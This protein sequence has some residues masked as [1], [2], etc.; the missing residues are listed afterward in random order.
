[1]RAGT[2]TL[3]SGF[4]PRW[5]SQHR[6]LDFAAK[7]GTPIYAAQGGTV[8]YI[9]RADGFGQWIVIDHPRRRRWRHDRLRTHVG[10]VRHRT[11]SRAARRGR[12]AHRLRRHER[13]IDRPTS[14]F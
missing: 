12:A 6:G 13:S 1:M 2:Y 8:A 5:G 14:A 9:G 3:S 4:G 10:R 7:D 11:T